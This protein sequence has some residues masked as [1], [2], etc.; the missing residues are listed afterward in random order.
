MKVRSRVAGPLTDPACGTA[1]TGTGDLLH[2][3]ERGAA[4]APPTSSSNGKCPFGTK[5]SHFPLRSS[6]NLGS[7]SRAGC[8]KSRNT[9]FPRNDRPA[10]LLSEKTPTSRQGRLQLRCPQVTLH[11]APG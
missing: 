1:R 8:R 3:N 4:S 5:S 10:C 11:Y 7:S 9:R 6:R 2:V